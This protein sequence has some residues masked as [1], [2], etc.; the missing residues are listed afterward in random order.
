MGD[1]GGRLIATECARAANSAGVSSIRCPSLINAGAWIDEA[2]E[3]YWDLGDHLRGVRSLAVSGSGRFIATVAENE[4]RCV[5]HMVSPLR[6]LAACV[7]KM[8]ENARV[9]TRVSL[10]LSLSL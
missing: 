5:V 2:C 9:S 3:G 4:C 1:G 10:S 7:R 8:C 6:C